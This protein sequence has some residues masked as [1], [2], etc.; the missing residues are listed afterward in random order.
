MKAIKMNH[1]NDGIKC[2]VNSCYFYGAG[3]CCTANQIEVQ[4]SDAESMEE[5]GCATFSQKY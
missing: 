2:S 1:P 4:P 3:D 5:T